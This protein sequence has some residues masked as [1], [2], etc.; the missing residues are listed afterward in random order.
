VQ[1]RICTIEPA[2]DERLIFIDLNVE[3]SFDGDNKPTWGDAAV[4]RIER[5]EADELPKGTTAY[6]FVVGC[7]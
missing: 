4:N 2:T 7:R 3:P 6:L 5:Y 1:P